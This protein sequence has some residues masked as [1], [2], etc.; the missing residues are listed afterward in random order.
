MAK[1][2]GTGSS[3]SD[4]VF[5]IT[6]RELRTDRTGFDIF[7]PRTSFAGPND[8]R[9]AEITGSGRTAKVTI[10][11]DKLTAADAPPSFLNAIPDELR[12]PPP[13]SPGGDDLAVGSRYAAGK[14]FERIKDRRRDLLLFVHGYNV[15]V[16]DAVKDARW[17]R[18]N[19]G[20]EPIVFSWPARGGGIRGTAEYLVDKREARASIE[21][22]DRVISKV[23][24]YL[25]ELR[26][27]A[28]AE[29]RSTARIAHPEDSPAEARQIAAAI[30]ALCPY[31]V[32]ALF[33]SM[34][35]YLLKKNLESGIS[36]VT[37]NT[38]FDNV[39]LVAADTNHENHANW[40]TRIRARRRVYV[41]INEDDYALSV[42]RLKIGDE[43]KARLGHTTTGLDAW[44]ARY[45]DVTDARSIGRGHGYFTTSRT[46]NPDVFKFFR[47]GV[48]GLRAED[49]LAYYEDTNTYRPTV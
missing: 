3:D 4:S 45:V 10:V 28:I 37:R 31:R 23:A 41:V 24:D 25:D 39:L 34:G 27:G 42:S 46:E 49:E 18:K 6:N 9:V 33:H 38:V 15:T 5:V 17:L 2:S 47:K 26:S 12:P 14:L 43:Q 7:G 32:S 20:V 22:L 35:N 8:L 48:R 29:I 30:E 36:F 13:D 11:P 19:F 44:N 40:V 1:R 21:A 16:E